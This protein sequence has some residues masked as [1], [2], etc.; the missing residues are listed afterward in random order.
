[1]TRGRA[2]KT[3][4]VDRSRMSALPLIAAALITAASFTPSFGEP[5]PDQRVIQIGA[6][7][8]VATV[9]V[10]IGKSEDVRTDTSFVEINVGDPEIA[11]VNPLTDKSL[12][13]LG[14][15]NGTTRISMYAEGKRLIGVFDVEA[16]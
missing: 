5:Q 4:L 14:K 2:S 3:Y 7:K 6:N 9:Q 12:S 8:R 11:D 16:I 13:I 15:K 1:M 10:L